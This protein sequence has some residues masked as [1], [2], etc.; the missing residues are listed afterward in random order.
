[1]NTSKIFRPFFLT[2]LWIGLLSGCS[3][4]TPTPTAEQPLSTVQPEKTIVGDTSTTGSDAVT[5]QTPEETGTILVLTADEVTTLEPYRLVNV[6]PEG[7]VASHLWDTLTLLNDDLQIEPHLAD[8]WR[9]INNF[10]WEFTLR[11]GITFHNGEPLDAQAVYFSIERARSMLGSLET[12]AQDVGLESVQIVNDHVLQIIT[13]QPVS[14]LPYYLAFLEILPPIYYSETD[15]DQLAIA[16]VGSGPYQVDQWTRGN[17][18]ILDAVPTYWKGAPA[19]PRLIFQTVP[20]AQDRLAAVYNG[21]AALVT[22]LPPMQIAQ[23]NSPNSRLEAIESTQ[24][25]FIGIRVGEGGPLADKR[26]RQALNYGVNVEYI[27]DN[28]LAGY[29]ERYG[30]WVNSPSNNLSLAAWPYDPALARELLVEAGYPEGFTT[31]L[32]TPA[33]VYYQDVTIAQAIAQQ[34]GEIEI[35]IEVKTINWDAY[36]RKLL[37]DTPPSLFLLGLNSRGD[38]LEDVRNLSSAFVFNPTGWQNELFETTLERAAKTFN[39]NTRAKLINDAQA[40]AYD[41]APWIWLWRQYDFYG[42]TQ[43]LDWTPRRDGLICLYKP[44]A[45]PS[46]DTE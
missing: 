41:E 23:W 12:F 37:S 34:L 2:L 44:V 8:S 15:P 42:I 16:P 31:T 24:R 22:D 9:L 20:Q 46:K 19:W 17:A 39:E 18:L 30:S 35:T 40:I 33:D 3:K 5:P 13:H 21:E 38:G 29:G 1:M 26:V 32:Y 7:S 11:Q 4:Q 28:W 10:T 43:S 36:V 45:A 27:L 25:M 6:H 14:N